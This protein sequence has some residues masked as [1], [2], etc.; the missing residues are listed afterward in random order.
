MRSTRRESVSTVVAV[1]SKEADTSFMLRLRFSYLAAGVTIAIVL[2]SSMTFAH[3]S[4]CHRWHTCPSDTG[5]YQMEFNS[6]GTAVQYCGSK[7]YMG[8][9]GHCHFFSTTG[10][11][12]TSVPTSNAPVRSSVSSVESGNWCG[13]NMHT[14]NHGCVC[15]TGFYRSGAGCVFSSCPVGT[16][17][18]SIKDNCEY[19]TAASDPSLRI[20]CLSRNPCKCKAGYAPMGNRICVP[21]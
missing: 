10:S 13:P 19:T 18:N 8:S 17:L 5:S 15:N 3:Q 21:K 4:G 9:D 14:H 1:I 7:M 16:R 20:A 2:P 6:N 12:P 11:S